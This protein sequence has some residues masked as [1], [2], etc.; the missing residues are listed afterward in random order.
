[1]LKSESKQNFS[2]SKPTASFN[3]PPSFLNGSQSPLSKSTLSGP[4]APPAM[5]TPKRANMRA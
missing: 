4:S 3:D 5:T 1:M 2:S